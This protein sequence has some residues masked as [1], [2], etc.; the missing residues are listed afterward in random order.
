LTRLVRATEVIGLPVVTL[1]TAVAVGEV[2]DVLF[3]PSRSRVVAFTVR[4]R[5]LLSSP[6]LGLLPGAAISAIGRDA[7]MIATA[8]ALV[9]E[10]S[11]MAS[12]LDDQI[13]VLGKEVVSDGGGTLGNVLDVVLEVEGGDATVVGA[14]IER[15]GEG[16]VILPLP[17]GTPVSADALVVPA[18]A[19]PY[20][21]NGL[22]GFREVLARARG[23]GEAEA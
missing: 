13:E 18:A 8:D 1:D 16:A 22:G 15:A 12:T 2:R 10:R 11:G 14:E 17:S 7:V 20:A 4:G 3:D 6:L 23:G 9:H 5:G 19:E 21:A